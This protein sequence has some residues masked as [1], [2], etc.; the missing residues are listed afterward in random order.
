[1]KKRES[2]IFSVGASMEESSH[3]FVIGL[4]NKNKEVICCHLHVWIISWWQF[5][6]K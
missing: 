5:H 6:E 3:A 4:K 2:N 1:L